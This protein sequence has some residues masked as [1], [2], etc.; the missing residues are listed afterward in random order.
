MELTLEQARELL[1]KAEPMEFNGRTYYPI[2][3]IR[4]LKAERFAK[5]NRIKKAN[6]YISAILRRYKLELFAELEIATDNLGALFERCVNDKL[7]GCR[8]TANVG[9]NLIPDEDIK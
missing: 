3:A 2:E 7:K 6:E 1:D 4:R 9:F 5:M 8:L